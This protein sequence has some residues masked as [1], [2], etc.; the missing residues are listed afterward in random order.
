MT[1]SFPIPVFPVGISALSLRDWIGFDEQL[2]Q[3][4]IKLLA[5]RLQLHRITD[6][7]K[8]MIGQKSTHDRR[9]AHELP[10]ALDKI[11]ATVEFVEKKFTR[12]Q[13]SRIIAQ[14]LVSR[15]QAP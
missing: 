5:D 8:Q 7:S 10:I 9:S 13:V 12:W 11:P 2:G 15:V 6:G 1:P 14:I 3:G 4:Q